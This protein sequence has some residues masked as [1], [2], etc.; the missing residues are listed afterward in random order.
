MSI[1]I[2]AVVG[3]GAGTAFAQVI[4]IDEVPERLAMAKS[5]KADVIDF[6]KDD[7]YES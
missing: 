4:L 1:A 3:V 5:S 2:A 6:S 7:V